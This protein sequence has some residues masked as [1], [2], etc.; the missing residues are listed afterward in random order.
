MRVRSTRVR[1]ARARSLLG[2]LVAILA[3]LGAVLVG[4]ASSASACSTKTCGAA[5]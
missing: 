1:R 4:G 3:L 5:I 2:P